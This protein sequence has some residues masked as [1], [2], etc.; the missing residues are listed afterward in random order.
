MEAFREEREVERILKG[1][2]E[3]RNTIREHVAPRLQLVVLAP[4]IKNSIY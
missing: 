1:V 2:E 4:R 3:V